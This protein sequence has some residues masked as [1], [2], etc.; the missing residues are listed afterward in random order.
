MEKEMQTI[1]EVVIKA[2]LIIIKESESKEKAIEKIE[3][4]LK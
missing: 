2:I 4:L 1:T 3:S